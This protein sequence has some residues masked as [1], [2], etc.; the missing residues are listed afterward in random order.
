MMLLFST[1]M[2]FFAA[3]VVFKNEID[4]AFLTLMGMVCLVYTAGAGMMF[5]LT[6]LAECLR[7]IA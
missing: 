1:A 3:A 7:A 4:V 6:I 2:A 5:V